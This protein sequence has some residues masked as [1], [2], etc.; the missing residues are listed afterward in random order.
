MYKKKNKIDNNLF[1]KLNNNILNDIYKNINKNNNI[2]NDIYKNI[3]KNNRYILV[4]GSHVTMYKK[5]D[6]YGSKK[7]IYKM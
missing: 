4:D 3:N 7:D 1:L 5:L 2:L 6:K